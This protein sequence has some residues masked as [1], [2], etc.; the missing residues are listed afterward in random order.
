MNIDMNILNKIFTNGICQY[1]E[2]T[3]HHN[4]MG[5]IVI[6]HWKII[7]IIHCSNKIKAKNYVIISVD[8]G[9]GFENIQLSI[10]DRDSH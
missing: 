9:K 2:R 3:V 7:S 5:F 6:L 10:C 8:V 4:K 1:I